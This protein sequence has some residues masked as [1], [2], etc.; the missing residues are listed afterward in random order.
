MERFAIVEDVAPRSEGIP[1]HAYPEDDEA[2]YVL[3]GTLVVFLGDEPSVRADAGAFVHIP[4]GVAH[5]FRVDSDRA[6][7]L[8]VT[9][10]QHGRFCRAISEPALFREGP[11][12]SSLD[13]EKIE[14]ACAAYG[15]EILGPPP[16]GG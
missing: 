11:P 10:P 1:R 14:A 6:R 7:Y 3:E 9:A 2:I 4:G 8:L 13:M 15:V 12:P 5:D 16:T